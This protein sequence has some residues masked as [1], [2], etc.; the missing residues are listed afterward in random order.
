MIRMRNNTKPDSVCC[1]CGQPRKKVLD[2][3][4]IQIGGEIFTICDL[5]NEALFYK[6][7]RASCNVNGRVKTKE[8]I[9]IINRRGRDRWNAKE[10]KEKINAD[11][12]YDKET[13]EQIKKSVNSFNDNGEDDE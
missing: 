13:Y 9:A 4:D 6:T 10:L 2:M 5:C 12:K 1:E 7:L 3:F 8:D 11:V